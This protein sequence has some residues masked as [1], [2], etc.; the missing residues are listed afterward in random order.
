MAPLS[1]PVTWHRSV[2]QTS[3]RIKTAPA[4][5]AHASAKPL[6]AGVSAWR[7][8]CFAR[9]HECVLA[10]ALMHYMCVSRWRGFREQRREA[11]H[12]LIVLVLQCAGCYRRLPLEPFTQ[13]STSA[14]SLAHGRSLT[15]SGERQDAGGRA[16]SPEREGSDALGQV[17]DKSRAAREQNTESPD[18]STESHAPVSHADTCG[19]HQPSTASQGDG[20]PWRQ[21]AD[22]AAS[23]REVGVGGPAQHPHPS[24]PVLMTASINGCPYQ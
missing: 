2:G 9:A 10:C 17:Q 12:G 3:R 21:H 23:L 24:L 20:R 15:V 22:A 7:G 6:E 11:V 16:M 19:Q 5:A 13:D 1:T 18:I 8:C 14:D 4:Q